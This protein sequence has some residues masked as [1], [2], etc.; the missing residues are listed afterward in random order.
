MKFSKG[1]YKVLDV[2]K[3]VVVKYWNVFRREVGASPS[4]E[5]FKTQIDKQ[6]AIHAPLL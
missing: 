2:R 3:N 1:N 4:P 5:M 6:P